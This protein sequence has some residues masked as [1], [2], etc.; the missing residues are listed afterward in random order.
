[1]SEEGERS[2]IW[3]IGRVMLSLMNRDMLHRSTDR[4]SLDTFADQ[5]DED[6]TPAYK[7]GV[8]NYYEDRCPKLVELVD[9]CLLHES[10]SRPCPA[11]LWQ[12]IQEEVG[13]FP[14][15]ATLPMKLREMPPTDAPPLCSNGAVLTGLSS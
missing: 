13:V 8:K 7:P 5:D 11:V 9:R 14:T 10:D 1:M 3:T 6:L 2:D 15:L 12:D 4:F